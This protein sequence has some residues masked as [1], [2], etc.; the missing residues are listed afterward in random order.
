MYRAVTTRYAGP[1]NS[2]GA[3][4]IARSVAGTKAIAWNYALSPYQ[5]HDAAALSV[6]REQELMVWTSDE[7]AP[8]AALPDGSGY[9]FLFAV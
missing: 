1:T 4:V 3:R 6:A 9:V 8:S 2:R 7:D 5:N